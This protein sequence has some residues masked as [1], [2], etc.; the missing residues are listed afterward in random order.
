MAA[1]PMNWQ[2]CMQ[3]EAVE[4]CAAAMR[5]N[6][7]EMSIVSPAAATMLA[8]APTPEAAVEIA[9]RGGTRQIVK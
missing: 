8:L 1:N 3:H 2:S 9:N 6:D 5:V 7:T 4:A